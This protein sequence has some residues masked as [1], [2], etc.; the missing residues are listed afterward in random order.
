MNSRVVVAVVS[1]T[2]TIPTEQLFDLEMM[3]CL[4][5]ETTEFIGNTEKT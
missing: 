3:R 2:E 4:E 1:A 5:K